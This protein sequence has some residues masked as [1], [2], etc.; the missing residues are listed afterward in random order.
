MGIRRRRRRK[1]IAAAA[2]GVLHR[3]LTAAWFAR[4]VVRSWRTAR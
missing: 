3:I 4:M 1:G 2:K